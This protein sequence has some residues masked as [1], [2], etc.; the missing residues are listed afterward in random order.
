[1]PHAAGAVAEVAEVVVVAE[2]RLLLRAVVPRTQ[3]P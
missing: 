2:E 1:M 3:G